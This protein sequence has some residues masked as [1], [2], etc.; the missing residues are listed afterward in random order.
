MGPLRLQ[1][2]DGAIALSCAPDGED[3]DALERAFDALEAHRVVAAAYG[4]ADA[5][6][7]AEERRRAPLASWAT[8]LRS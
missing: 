8:Q 1:T 7:S 5:H 6:E 4:D 3:A 2:D